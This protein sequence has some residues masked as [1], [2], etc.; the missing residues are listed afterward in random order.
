ML[1][2][3]DLAD[4]N[5]RKKYFRRESL[6]THFDENY[7]FTCSNKFSQKVIELK[8]QVINFLFNQLRAN[9]NNFKNKLT[10]LKDSYR[11]TVQLF[12]RIET[13]LY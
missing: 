2:L 12:F 1:I 13:K 8:T 3:T 10:I 5:H 4:Q 11:Y 9:S 7:S 6:N